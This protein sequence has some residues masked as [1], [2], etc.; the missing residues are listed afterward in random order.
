MLLKIRLL[1]LILLVLGVVVACGGEEEP[2]PTPESEVE[3]GNSGGAK[4]DVDADESP[5]AITTDFA[6]FDNETLGIAFEYPAGWIVEA[7]EGGGSIVIGSSQA[8]VESDEMPDEG[9]VVSIIPF[10]KDMLSLFAPEG[11]EVDSSDPLSILDIFVNQLFLSDTEE[12]IPTGDPETLTINGNAGAVQELRGSA[13]NDTPMVARTYA[14]A[15]EQAVVIIA[16]SPETSEAEMLPLIE[17]IVQSIVVSAPPATPTPE[18]TN[19]PE[20]TDTP[21]P[22]ATAE[23]SPTLEPTATPEPVVDVGDMT[24]FASETMGLS[25]SYPSDWAF[26]ADEEAGAIVLASSAEALETDDAPDEG[27]IATFLTLPAEFMPFFLPEDVEYD[28]ANP[29]P[30]IAVFQELFF[31]DEDVEFTAGDTESLTI[32]DL[33]AM[34]QE[35]RGVADNDVPLVMHITVITAPAHAVVAIAITPEAS[36]EQYLSILDMI[37]DSAEISNPAPILEDDGPETGDEVVVAPDLDELGQAHLW[38]YR[39]VASTQYTDS[40]WSATQATG[41][42]DTF[43]CGDLASAWASAESDTVDWLEVYVDTALIPTQINIHQT[44]NPDQVVTVELI[45][46]DGNLVSAYEAEPTVVEE[47]PYTLSIDLLGSTTIIQGARITVDQSA[48]GNWNEID[49]VEF[50]GFPAEGIELS[51]PTIPS[52]PPDGFVWRIGGETSIFDDGFSSIGGMDTDTNGNIY[53]ADNGHGVFILDSDGNQLDLIEH[54]DFWVINDVKVG[55]NGEIAVADWG[56]TS[57]YLFNSDGTFVTSF[58]GEGTAEGQ[59]GGFSPQYVAIGLDG[60][61]YVHDDNEDADGESYER[62]QKFAADGTFISAFTIDDDFFSTTGM[63]VGPDGNLYLVGFLGEVILAYDPDG[64]FI[65]RI[66]EDALD[67][68]SPRSLIIDDAGNFYIPTWDDEAVLKLDSEGN[69]VGT[70]GYSVDDGERE[71]GEGGFYSPQGIAVLGDGSRIFVSDW[72]GDFSY[73]TAFEIAE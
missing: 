44:Y 42:P 40:S 18:P 55:P 48:Q 39:A 7:D 23:P 22:T 11:T 9:G 17:A 38:A 60:S 56:S 2:T 1:L 64:N 46:I 5:S 6:T 14:I 37:V 58:G 63:D 68:Y 3:S 52:E 70:F 69:L 26:E 72:S 21:E 59:F 8:V 31:E 25:I 28:P 53:M 62:V 12:I 13:E 67:F 57:V 27:A 34:R 19:T 30:L 32:S 35:F 50:V 43:E 15:G 66:G 41:E 49:A 10:D 47:C 20:P 4:V 24:L 71:W 73:V 16:G 45:D 54:D 33:P 51:D 65:G 61:I 29:E 36:E